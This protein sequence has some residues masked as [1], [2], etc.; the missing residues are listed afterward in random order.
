MFHY[1]D[2]LSLNLLSGSGGDGCIS[3]YRTRK[4]PRGGPDGG[5]GGQGGSVIFS[6]SSK[7]DSLEHLKKTKR[8]KA[9]DGGTGGKQLKKG[10][11]GEDIVLNLPLGTLIRD[12]KERILK[13]FIAVKREIFLQGGKGGRGN[14]FFKNSRNQAPRRFQKGEK[15]LSQKVIL[16]HKPLIF[17][18]LIGKVNTGKSSFFNLVTRAQS[19][20]ADYPYTTL[21]PHLGQLKNVSPK[22]LIM[23]IPGLEKGSF[24][25]VL[26]GLSFLRSIQRADLLLHF[27]DSSGENPLRDKEEI[28]EELKNFDKERRDGYFEGLSCRKVFLILTKTDK[29]KDEKNWENLISKIHLKKNQ[30]I[31]PLSNKTKFGLKNILSSI[32]REIKQ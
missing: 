3:F 12:D 4:N 10:R 15:G 26:K 11:N 17:T 20:T 25:N 1:R 13:D 27:I 9:M 8:Y 24:K 28:E 31:F 7:I 29:L 6:S 30:K 18:A 5:D 2:Q 16:E 22:A 19:K 14:A 21:E 23:D 32:K